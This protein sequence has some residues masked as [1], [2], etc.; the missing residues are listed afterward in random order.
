VVVAVL[1]AGCGSDDNDGSA[2]APTSAKVA[3]SDSG[4]G[5]AAAVS[6][7]AA[8]KIPVLCAAEGRKSV[9]GKVPF[10]QCVKGLTKLKKGKAKNP[11]AACKGL[12]SKKSTGTLAKCPYG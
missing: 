1:A 2:K 12:S 6:A 5:E 4:G 10:S 7:T 9:K 3:A 8:P 11:R